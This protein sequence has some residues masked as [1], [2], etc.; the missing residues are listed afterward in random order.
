MKPLKNDS[1]F[2][3]HF[4]AVRQSS[5]YHEKKYGGA[6]FRNRDVSR[7]PVNVFWAYWEA[8]SVIKAGRRISFSP[9]P[10]GGIQSRAKQVVF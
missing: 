3:K 2:A 4:S 8:N 10:V 7:H 9:P 6:Y 5:Q 1:P